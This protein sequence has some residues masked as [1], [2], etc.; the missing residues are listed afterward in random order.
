MVKAWGEK[1][2]DQKTE[3]VVT[4][5]VFV[6]I[7]I[8]CLTMDYQDYKAVII[9]GFLFFI[10]EQTLKLFVK[11]YVAV[12]LLSLFITVSVPLIAF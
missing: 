7:A 10:L 8:S 1:T 6:V 2:L 5:A 3:F 12:A 9:L 4:M 11:D